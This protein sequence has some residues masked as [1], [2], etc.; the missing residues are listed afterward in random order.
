[1]RSGYKP[2]AHQVETVI[3]LLQHKRAYNFSDLGTGKTLSHLWCADFLMINDKIKKVLVISPL[4]TMQS[5]WANEIFT[6]LPHRRSR[7]VHGNRA[8]RIAALRSKA[9]FYI[10]NHDG[11]AIPEVEK[12]IIA[13]IHRGEIGL[14]VIDELTA[15]KKHT[16]NRSK[17]MQRITQAAGG[18]CGVHG[19]TG[20]PTPNGPS[21]SFGQ[22]KCVTPNNPALPRYFKQFQ[23]LV[24][25]QAGP[26]MWLPMPNATEVVARILQPAVRYKRDDCIDIPECQYV[27]RIVPFTEPQR[28]LYDQMKEHLLIEYGQGEITAVNAAVKMMKLLQIAAGS[29]K[30][31]EGNIVNTDASTR[32]DALWEIFEETGKTKLVVFAAFRASIERLVKFF[33]E[34]KVKV[35]TIHGSVDHADRAKYI[36]DFQDGDLQVLVIQPQSS[37]HGITLTASNTIV[38]YSLVASGEVHHQANGRITRAGQKRKQLIYYLIGCKAEKHILNLLQKKSNMSH[39]VLGLFEEL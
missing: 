1:M 32:E 8:E 36:K 21:E 39:A 19:L 12:E 25:Y 22:A 2:F 18:K 33:R 15:Y 7:I 6:N 31:D 34:R 5:V 9:D 20:A 24:E 37:A 23:P 26:Y 17:A 16:T 10:L 28:K 13:M 29:V 27:E 3:F 38:W 14:I 35:A 4:S 30:D 11:V